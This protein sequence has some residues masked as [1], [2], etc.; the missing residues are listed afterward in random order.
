M[1]ESSKD[2]TVDPIEVLNRCPVGAMLP[3]I[4]QQSYGSPIE[5]VFGI[6][7][8]SQ[9]IPLINNNP[10]AIRMAALEEKGVFLIPI[11]IR[12]NYLGFHPEYFECW[13][14]LF[15]EDA[16]GAEIF[17]I[18]SRQKR[19]VLQLYGDSEEIERIMIIAHNCREYWSNLES[20]IDHKRSW[21]DEEFEKAREEIYRRFTTP[22]DLFNYLGEKEM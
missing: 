8:E 7:V 10:I 21:S 17:R 1:I 19:L 9:R 11:I 14:N 22:K 12:L 13:L 2:W 20:V 3:L 5:V 4:G 18:I 6:R 16:I 15:P